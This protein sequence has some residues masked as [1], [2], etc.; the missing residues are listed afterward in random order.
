MSHSSDDT[1]DPQFGLAMDQ[2]ITS[3]LDAIEQEKI[4]DRLTRLA[5]ELQNALVEKRR[6]DVQ[7]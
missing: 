4:P 6:R 3:L 7:N 2:K 1:A 5:M